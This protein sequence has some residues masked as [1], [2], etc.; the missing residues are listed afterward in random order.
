MKTVNIG[1]IGCGGMARSHVDV[2][3]N[4]PGAHVRGCWNR[5]QEA[6]LAIR[7]KDYSRADYIASDYHELC[8]DPEIDVIYIC[9]MHND[10]GP[11]S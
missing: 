2:L 10:R 1:F 8:Q 11:I 4:L 3:A 5:P 9:T 6:E 7:F